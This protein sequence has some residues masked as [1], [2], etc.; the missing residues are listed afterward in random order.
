MKRFGLAALLSIAISSGLSAAPQVRP[1][2]INPDGTVT[3]VVTM[4]SEDYAVARAAFR[5]R[6]TR[7]GP[8]PQRLPMPATP[9]GARE[10]DFPSG[11]LS[12]RAW[13][14]MP[15]GETRRPPVVVFV[16]GGFGFG[17]EDF[18]M[19]A[20]YRAAGFAVVTP[21]LRGE[22]GQPGSFSLFY[23]E[24]ADVLALAQFL[25]RQSYVDGTRLYLAGHSSGGTV[26]LLA[27]MAG[28]EFRA[29]ATF[30]ASPDQVL[31]VRHGIRPADVPFDSEDERELQMRSPLA[32]AASLK[33]PARLY[34]GSEE[35][36]FRLGTERLAAAAAAAG[37][38]VSARRV[39][40]THMSA[41]PAE[42]AA[43]IDFFRSR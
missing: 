15:P 17:Q 22:N 2:Q 6:L 5:T 12:L 16:H 40:G 23:D 33:A 9:D 36:F 7:Q 1:M 26:A 14:G 42:I 24:A 39:P 3:P 32:Y 31:F 43:S 19:A 11:S 4:S 38:D 28:R 27:A 10:I 13:V 25:R 20:P 18:D 8:S 41:V 37:L 21:I 29:V 30:S 35:G 34:F